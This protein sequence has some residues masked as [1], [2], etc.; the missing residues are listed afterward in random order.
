MLCD[1]SC[2][3]KEGEGKTDTRRS[4]WGREGG[5]EGGRGGGVYVRN[6]PAKQQNG[7]KVQTR[8]WMCL[9]FLSR[10]FFSSMSTIIII[11]GPVSLSVDLF[12]I[13]CLFLSF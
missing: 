10:S 11:I 9:L 6:K 7:K 3:F 4:V 13:D 5:R 2:I 8:L 12:F 1:V